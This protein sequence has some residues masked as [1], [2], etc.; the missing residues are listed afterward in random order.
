VPEP[1][2]PPLDA[3]AV[4]ARVTRPGSVWREIAVVASTGST[5]AD[6]LAMAAEGAA[7]G[8]VLAAEEQSAG[9]GRLG[10]T[11]TAPPRSGLAVSVLLRPRRPVADLGWLP[12]LTGLAVAEAVRATAGVAGTVKW[13]NDVLVGDRKLAGVL[14]ERSGEAVVVGIGLNVGLPA[15][16]LPVAT[17]TSLR[18]EGA[19]VDGAA[20]RHEVLCALLDRLGA[21][22]RGWDAGGDGPGEELWTA[23]VAASATVG[24]AVRAELPGGGTVE[25]DAVDVDRHGR[26]VV[27]T[28]D[29][30]VPVSAGDVVH[31]RRGG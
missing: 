8:V 20:S 30:R 1:L 24:S 5:N 10:R 13:P 7:E 15:D 19:D 29:G 28:P 14:A 2:P 18:V 26:L 3:T 6:L 11:W 21:R 4:A 9:R 27:R 25:G 22:Y 16:A 12:L 23:Y 17:A 31:L